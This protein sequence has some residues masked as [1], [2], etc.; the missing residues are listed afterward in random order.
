MNDADKKTLTPEDFIFET[1]APIVVNS[2]P[3]EITPEM[4]TAPVQE[5]AQ[6]VVAAPT[7]TVD[8]GYTEGLPVMDDENGTPEERMKEDMKSAF[9]GKGILE[10]RIKG[11]TVLSFF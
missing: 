10:M 11:L 8:N 5:E 3:S 6:P 4:T 7:V 1:E 9:E 2:T